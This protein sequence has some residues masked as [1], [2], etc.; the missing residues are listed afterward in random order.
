[1]N[2]NKLLK[3]ID[4]VSNIIGVKKYVLRHWE[5]RLI[6]LGSRALIL[7][8][9]SDNKRRYYRDS[10][11]EILKRIKYLL[12]TKKYTMEGIA[13]ELNSKNKNKEKNS[14]MIDL[15]KKLKSVSNELKYLIKN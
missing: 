5:A 2:N 12:Y 3:N 13:K 8:K 9:G 10:D 7:K 15:I 11:I 14:D 1:L 4:D 6:D